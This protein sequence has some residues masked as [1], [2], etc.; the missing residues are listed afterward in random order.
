MRNTYTPSN[1]VV[2]NEDTTID[3][4]GTATTFPPGSY[5]GQ[6]MQAQIDAE[7]PIQIDDPYPSSSE[8][9][10][11]KAN[12]Y[13]KSLEGALE[14]L[15]QVNLV[16]CADLSE[17]YYAG[18]YATEGAECNYDMYDLSSWAPDYGDPQTYLD[19]FLP[20]YAGYC[21]KC[22]GIY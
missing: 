6:I 20:D 18:Y 13:K 7:H 14:G 5:Y 9:Y 1:F 17:W 22:L 15:V 2:L 21:T 16:S 11:N 8:T 3:I 19:T 4:N 12:A 10:T